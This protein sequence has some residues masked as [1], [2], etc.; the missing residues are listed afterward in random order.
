MLLINANLGVTFSTVFNI[1]SKFYKVMKLLSM[2]LM[3]AVPIERKN[4]K[5]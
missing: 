1:T 3:N 4:M 2:R 5:K